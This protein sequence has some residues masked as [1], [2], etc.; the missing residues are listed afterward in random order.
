MQPNTNKHMA[1]ILLHDHQRLLPMKWRDEIMDVEQKNDWRAAIELLERAD[2]NRQEL[3]L[4]VIF[5]L[6]DFVVE[7]QYTREEHDYAAKKL[8]DFF[9]ESQAKFSHDAEY[10]FFAGIIIYIGEWYFGM[11]SVE[12]ATSM[13]EKAMTAEPNNTLYEWGYYSRIDQRPEQN[14][15]LK[16][17]LSENL[18]FKETSKLDWLRNKG[19]L[20]KYVLGTLE[21][22]YEDIKAIK[23]SQ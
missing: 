14:T 15:D 17:R 5:L 7:G 9:A 2:G 3:Y 11:D 22:T 19:L 10:L 16:L 1:T 23:S 13:L 8:K 18:L 6:L 21:G 20:G 4:R 12:P